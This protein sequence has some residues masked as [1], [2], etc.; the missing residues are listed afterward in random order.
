MS[1]RVGGRKEGRMDRLEENFDRFATNNKNRDP[2][3]NSDE[4]DEDMMMMGGR[5]DMFQFDRLSH[6][7]SS[8]RSELSLSRLG[9]V[10][11]AASTPDIEAMRR[12]SKTHFEETKTTA[13]NEVPKK[14]SNFTD[15][16]VTRKSSNSDIESVRRPSSNALEL[17]DTNINSGRKRRVEDS[18]RIWKEDER[19]EDEGEIAVERMTSD[20]RPPSAETV[21]EDYSL[22]SYHQ[23]AAKHSLKQQLTSD[24]FRQCLQA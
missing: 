6:C 24:T 10:S 11:P 9:T 4:E 16:E 18:R 1:S 17:F 7:S 3:V 13:V 5:D 20:E 22:P 12:P 19:K 23:V 2:G 15:F 21:A 8:L 14:L